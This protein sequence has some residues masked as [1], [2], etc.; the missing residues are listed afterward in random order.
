MP[1]YGWSLAA[2]PHYSRPSA[3]ATPHYYRSSAAAAPHY[4]RPSAAAAPHYSRPSAAAVPY[5]SPRGTPLRHQPELVQ[6]PGLLVG[7]RVTRQTCH[8][9]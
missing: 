8:G 9:Q 1:S 5:Y 4:S 3:A 7:P 2:A 6:P